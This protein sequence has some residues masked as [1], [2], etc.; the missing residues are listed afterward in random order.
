MTLLWIRWH[1]GVVIWCI[2]FRSESYC[3]CREKCSCSISTSWKVNSFSSAIFVLGAHPTKS[4]WTGVAIW[5]YRGQC[6]LNISEVL[7]HSP[8]S[9]FKEMLKISIL[10]ISLWYVELI[11]YPFVNNSGNWPC[12][13]GTALCTYR[14]TSNISRTQSQHLIVSRLILQLSLPSPLKPGVKSRMKM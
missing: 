8:E 2:K 9:N 1:R 12:Y 6:W 13:N 10:F 3:Q 14:K 4:V 11:S 5:C 7:W